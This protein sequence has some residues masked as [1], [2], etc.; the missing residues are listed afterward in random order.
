MGDSQIHCVLNTLAWQRLV[1]LTATDSSREFEALIDNWLCHMQRVRIDPLIWA[2][3]LRTHRKLALRSGVTSIFSPTIELTARV[4]VYK[5]PSGDE[6]TQAVALKPLVILRVLRLGFEI[7]FLDV[8]VAVMQDPRPWLAQHAAADMQVSLNFDA[9]PEYQK[10]LPTGPA[11]NTGVLY[12][13]PSRAVSAV[14]SSWSRRTSARHMCPREPPFWTCGDQEQLS[15]L[16]IEC[17]WRPLS[18]NAAAALTDNAQFQ[19]RC[20]GAVR[21]SGRTGPQPLMQISVVGQ[22]MALRIDVLP[23]RLFASGRSQALWMS[24]G[25]LSSDYDVSTFHANFV[26]LA[27][28]SKKQFLKRTKLGGVVLWCA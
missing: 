12:A 15:R 6:Y 27:E 17:G 13:R 5:T 24:P 14:V 19:L 22:P 25:S 20:G 28:G 26:A 18:F 7:L 21:G 4:N 11:V 3:D 1:T 10:R 16:L 9:R 23:P 8:D 2:L